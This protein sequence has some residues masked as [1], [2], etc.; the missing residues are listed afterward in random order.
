MTA[1]LAL[2]PLQIALVLVLLALPILPNLW[3]IWHAYWREFPSL[4]E[5][6]IWLVLAVFIPV[7]GG[8]AYMAV[9][10]KRGRKPDAA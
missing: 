10:R 7:L 5:K 2:S 1:L 3:S 4:N 9:G 6:M 8:I